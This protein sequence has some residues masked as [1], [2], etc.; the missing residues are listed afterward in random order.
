M[1]YR[2][3]SPVV[4]RITGRPVE[5]FM[6]GPDHWLSTIHPDDRARLV[7]ASARII[8]GGS[9]EEAEEYRILRP[10]GTVRWVRQR[11]CTEASRWVNPPRRRGVRHYRTKA[12]RREAAKHRALLHATI[13][14]LPFDFFALGSDGRYFLQNAASKASWGDAAGKLPEEVCPNNEDLALWLDNNRRALCGETV[15]AE[16]TLTRHG[17]KRSYYNVIAPI[18]GETETYGILGVNVD[19]TGRKRAEAALRQT[20]EELND[21]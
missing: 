10:D 6:Q 7:A 4:E 2:Y 21:E 19:I 17:E 18:R 9:V 15:E 3:Y 16:V 13:D 14:C 8:S 12:G 5:F 20:H 1:T 11:G